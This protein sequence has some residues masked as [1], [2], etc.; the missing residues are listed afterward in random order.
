MLGGKII[1]TTCEHRCFKITKGN[2]EEID[3]LNTTQQEADTRILL[4]EA[5]V[6]KAG[7]KAVIITAEDTDILVLALG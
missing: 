7:Y 2:W 3:E 1:F 5:H 4:H 6:A